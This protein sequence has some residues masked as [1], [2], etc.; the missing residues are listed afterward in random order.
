MAL[1]LWLQR[2]G[3]NADVGDAGLL[4]GI[5]DGGEGAKGY[6]L[7]GPQIDDALGPFRFAGG[8]QQ[9]GEL[10]DVNRLVL[11]EDVLLAV[12]GDDHALFGE[13]ING[14]RLGD[15]H[16]DAGLKHRCGEHEDEQKHEN[17]IDQ[18]SDVDL[19]ECG[20]RVSL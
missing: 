4:D 12:D 17:D 16:F 14:T 13:L 9:R 5:H 20:L 19:G 2:L 15:C 3:H 6:A 7:V 1:S 10:V 11:Q 8:L 18:W